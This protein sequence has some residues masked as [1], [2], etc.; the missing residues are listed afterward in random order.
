[1][2][3]EIDNIVVI[4][5]FDYDELVEKANANDAEIAKQAESLFIKNNLIPVRIEFS[6]YRNN[7]NFSAPVGF[8][9]SIHTDKVYDALDKIEPKIREWMDENMS[10][11][12]RKLRE[13]NITEKNCIGL[14]K[15]VVNLEEKLKRQR[16][17]YTFLFS[18]AVVI[19]VIVFFLLSYLI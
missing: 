13:K 11:Y 8:V 16:I 19:S 14:S 4:D 3:K 1:M 5:R 15:R 12:D 6:E 10:M 7:K 18:Y 9:R 17:K 2:N